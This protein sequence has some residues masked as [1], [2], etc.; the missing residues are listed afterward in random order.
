MLN[1]LQTALIQV[2]AVMIL[3][4]LVYL[5]RRFTFHSR[6]MSFAEYLGLRLTKLDRT[7]F[8]ILTAMVLLAV[9]MTAL[10]FQLEDGWRE[11]LRSDSSP[12][13]KIIFQLGFGWQAMVA[14]FIYSFFAASMAE[15]IL[16]RGLIAKSLISALGIYWGN[17]LQALVF[18][19]A[20]LVMIRIISHQWFSIIQLETF[21]V[22]FGSG[23]ICGYVNYRSQRASIF[24]SWILHGAT[25]MATFVTI[26]VLLQD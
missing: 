4:A 25:N 14:G 22:S 1:Q 17:I 21:I 8:N 26:I 19:L 2:L 6:N 20:H 18:W 9:A 5:T 10:Q 12:Y 24:P 15:E 13:G 23:L 7:F 3:S 11:F 16:F